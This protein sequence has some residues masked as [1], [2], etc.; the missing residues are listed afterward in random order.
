MFS[1]RHVLKQL[2]ARRHCRVWQPARCP[3]GLR[4]RRTRAAARYHM[5][6]ELPQA[7]VW[8]AFGATSEIWGRHYKEVQ[9]T[10]GGWC[11]P[12]CPIPGQRALPRG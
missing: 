3:C 1:R 7:L 4:R 12:W 8:V 5:P 6:E 10:I 11:R 2:V 9:A